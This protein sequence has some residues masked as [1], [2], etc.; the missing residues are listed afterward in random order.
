[1][2]KR[3]LISVAAMFVMFVATGFLVHGLLLAPDYTLLPNLFRSDADQMKYM[4]FMMLAHLFAA[5]AFVWI[6]L[7]IKK[8]KPFLAQGVCYG[9]AV[10]A[11]TIVPKFLIYYAVQPMP[12]AIVCKQI[13]FDT[14]SVVLMG[15][16]VARINK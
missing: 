12:A 2:S 10:A 3:P 1:M 4:P 11:L 9:L 6:Y 14:I 15:I 7:E 8:D 16:V 5:F 13:I